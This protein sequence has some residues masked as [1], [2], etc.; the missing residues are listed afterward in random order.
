MDVV[1]SFIAWDAFVTVSRA[2]CIRPSASPARVAF[3]SAV[4]EISASEAEV[5][6]MPKRPAPGHRA[7]PPDC[8]P[9]CLA[10]RW[11]P[12]LRPIARRQSRAVL[13][14]W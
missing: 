13:D 3:C 11:Q 5:S 14:R 9:T 4:A 7:V 12:R 10:R 2:C 6:S 8:T 1:R